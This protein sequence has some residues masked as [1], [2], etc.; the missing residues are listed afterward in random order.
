MKIS[1]IAKTFALV[2]VVAA[3]STLPAF[4]IMQTP[5][6][7]RPIKSQADLVA[8]LNVADHLGF[9]LSKLSSE[10]LQEF[11]KSIS[12]NA[13]GVTGFRYD[14]LQNELTPSEIN[15]VITAFRIRALTNPKQQVL[16]NYACIG[17]ACVYAPH[18]VCENC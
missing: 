2:V 18:F 3:T 9:P 10:E 1:R 4:S 15:T 17:H 8:Y 16:Y 11:I 12:F 14:I 7:G 13:K 5:G 6:F